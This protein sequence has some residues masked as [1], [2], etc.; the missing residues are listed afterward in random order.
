[1]ISKQLE[2]S[3]ELCTLFYLTCSCTQNAMLNM[4]FRKYTHNAPFI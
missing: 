1:M 3:K 2:L 4:K